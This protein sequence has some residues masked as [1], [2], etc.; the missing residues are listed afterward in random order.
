MKADFKNTVTEHFSVLTRVLKAT[1]L[2]RN[3]LLAIPEVGLFL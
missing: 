1:Q 2:T 3:I